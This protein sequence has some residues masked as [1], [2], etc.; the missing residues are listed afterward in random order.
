M[1]NRLALTCFLEHFHYIRANDK[2]STSFLE[3]IVGVKGVK[4]TLKLFGELDHIS[5]NISEIIKDQ[6]SRKSMKLVFFNDE[7]VSC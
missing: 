3:A 6:F 7:F 4:T 5:S 1:C 2:Y